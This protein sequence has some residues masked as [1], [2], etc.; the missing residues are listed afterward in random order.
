MAK[1]DKNTL[2]F[3]TTHDFYSITQN[4]PRVSTMSGKPSSDNEFG[5]P[6]TFTSQI[7]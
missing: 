3:L 6:C 4:L 5:P 1:C 7:K 2:N